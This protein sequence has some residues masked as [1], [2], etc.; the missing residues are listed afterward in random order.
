MPCFQNQYC[1]IYLKLL[2]QEEHTKLN[3]ISKYY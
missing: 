1:K 2:N 3:T